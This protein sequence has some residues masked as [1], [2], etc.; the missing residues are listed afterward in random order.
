L[1]Q[2]FQG[3]FEFLWNILLDLSLLESDAPL[4]FLYG[5]GDDSIF[6]LEE[7]PTSTAY[8]HYP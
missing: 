1:S 4:L 7:L 3:D 2:A 5:V 8:E 6:F